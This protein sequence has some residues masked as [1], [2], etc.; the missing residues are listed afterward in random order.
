MSC[1]GVQRHRREVKCAQLRNTA[2]GDCTA[3]G[4]DACVLWKRQMH[5][6]KRKMLVIYLRGSRITGTTHWA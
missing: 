3:S 2:V 1:Q 4:S 6:D 5:G